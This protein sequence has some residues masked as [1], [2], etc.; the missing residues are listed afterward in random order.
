MKKQNLSSDSWIDLF[1]N[2]LAA[3]GYL[4][5]TQENCFSQERDR[6]RTIAREA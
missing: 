4:S 3:Q 2:W 5:P 6:L 1:R